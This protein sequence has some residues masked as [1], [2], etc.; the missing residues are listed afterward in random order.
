M[1]F[2]VLATVGHFTNALIFCVCTICIA[3]TVGIEGTACTYACNLLLLLHAQQL[4]DY[5]DDFII[6]QATGSEAAVYYSPTILQQA[7][8]TSR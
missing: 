2:R 5:V 3:A 7:G 1:Y 4:T 8:I 6:T